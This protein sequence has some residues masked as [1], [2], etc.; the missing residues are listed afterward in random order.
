MILKD[1]INYVQEVEMSRAAYQAL[2]VQNI[3]LE[4]ATIIDDPLSDPK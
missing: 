2:T 3:P 1:E 4:K